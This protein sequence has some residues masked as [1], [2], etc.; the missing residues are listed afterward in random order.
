MIEH[1]GFVSIISGLM[2]V[3][4]A[5]WVLA[6]IFWR[7][8]RRQT[9]HLQAFIEA[10]YDTLSS[11][12]QDRSL[13]E[14]LTDICEL[15]EL[16]IKDCFASVMMVNQEGTALNAVAVNTLPPEFTKALQN[17]PIIDGVGACGTAAA[18]KQPVIVEDMHRDTRFELFTTLVEHYKLRAAWSIP[19]FAPGDKHLLG[20]FALYSSQARAPTDAELKLIERSRDLI[21][22]VITQHNDRMERERSEQHALSLFTH[23]PEAVFTLDREGRF[24]SL[25]NAGEKLLELTEQ[26]VV[27]QHYEMVVL[28]EDKA[29][30]K[31]HFEAT[32]R[33]E[34][35]HYEIRIFNNHG[36]VRQIEITNMPI[37]IHGQIT[38]VHGIAKDVTQ[39]RDYEERLQILD[40]SVEASTNGV[41]I[42]DAR[43]KGFPI[44]Y[45]NPAFT[46]MSGYSADDMVGRSCRILQG[47][48]S[49]PNTVKEIASALRA[50]TEI[51]CTIR[52]YRKDGTPFWNELIIS[53][54]RDSNGEVTHFVGLQND[55]SERVEREEKLA[56]HAEHD[57]LTGL[58]NRTAL[59]RFLQQAAAM[60][61]QR[62]YVLF[63]D[64]DG[65]KPV[66]DS[67]G[68]E[69]G[70]H[71]LVQTAQRLQKVT[72][73]FDLLARFGGDEFVAVVQSL[74]DDESVMNYARTILAQFDRPF[75]YEDAEVSLSAAIGIASSELAVKTPNE[76]I[77]HADV[78]MYEAKRRG[79]NTFQWFSP[80][81]DLDTQQQITL[82]AQLQEAIQT[83]QFEV[84][85][86]PIVSRNG[87][88]VAVEALLRWNHPERGYVSPADF[89]PLAE[90][91]GQIVAMGHWVLEQACKD[92]AR[93]REAGIA[94]VSVNFSPMQFYR[95][96]F[97]ESVAKL[98][99]KYKI[100][101]NQLMAEITENVLLRDSASALKMMAD[102]RD[103]GL[104]IALD[105]FGTGFASLSYLNVIPAQKLKIDRCFV[106]NIES[107]TRNAA[108]TRGVL[109]M[110]A[111]LGISAVAEGV[112]T[113]AE[114][115]YL[116]RYACDYMQ[117]YLFCRPQPI[118]KLL[119]WLDHK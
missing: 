85:Y 15:V 81:L 82:R 88:V 1:W 24:M 3:T 55:I 109:T 36:Q 112:E 75:V 44:I 103:L 101:P 7:R 73:E 78:A 102:L 59:E 58:P 37:I 99:A 117:G 84:F 91:T 54:V 48:K 51:R 95:D 63:I 2:L 83:H 86:Q 39:Q 113:E 9:K 105:D 66:N 108:I 50:Q 25:N 34:P 43:K 64:L 67:L 100:Q 98:V 97:I 32:K 23:N 12:A 70:D 71:I 45:V 74:P 29:R 8:A 80:D 65:F 28:E 30:T 26:Q 92:A 21:S 119:A 52:N 38:G 41:V 93:L 72:S 79:S 33:G 4:A 11:L 118:N 68:H 57:V 10:E 104:E 111:E 90:R 19:V 107:N 60:S 115:D 46:L 35:Q 13:A 53:P 22:L 116:T 89:I 18:L 5:A 40:R 47:P 62:I 110:A 114:R 56:F 17:I 14:K 87:A 77:Q 94:Q 61:E 20:T 6:I 69:C 31:E 42:S 106:Q 16:Q 27:G 49:D 76:M 96:D